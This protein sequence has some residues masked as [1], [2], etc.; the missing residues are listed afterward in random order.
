MLAP[1]AELAGFRKNPGAMG[2]YRPA[3]PTGRWCA[4]CD[5]LSAAAAPFL[6]P[7]SRAGDAVHSVLGKLFRRFILHAFSKHAVE[8][9]TDCFLVIGFLIFTFPIDIF[10][11][12]LRMWLMYS[13]YP[14]MYGNATPT[15]DERQIIV[16]LKKGLTRIPRIRG[17]GW[18]GPLLCC[19]ELPKCRKH[20]DSKLGFWGPDAH[21]PQLAQPEQPECPSECVRTSHTPLSSPN[22]LGRTA[23]SRT[24]SNP[25][26]ES[27]TSLYPRTSLT[28]RHARSMPSASEQHGLSAMFSGGDGTR[29]RSYQRMPPPNT[30]LNPP[31]D[32]PVLSRARSSRLPSYD[33]SIHQSAKSLSTCC[34]SSLTANPV[35]GQA[36]PVFDRSLNGYRHYGADGF[37]PTGFDRKDGGKMQDQ[38]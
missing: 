33:Q 18:L 12:C 14:S 20:K 28:S 25:T 37:P 22:D 11:I 26:T 16:W 2:G 13:F 30:S 31:P 29:R 8:A 19:P 1:F 5:K 38:G 9:T 4:A 10:C 15:C 23:R 27:P 32:G 17:F 7:L 24:T 34:P 35:F 3:H 21:Y 36:E 6:Q